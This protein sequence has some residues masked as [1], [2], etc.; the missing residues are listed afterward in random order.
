[1]LSG[2][3]S[4]GGFRAQNCRYSSPRLTL[5]LAEGGYQHDHKTVLNSLQRQGLRAMEAKKFKATTNSNHGLVAPQSVEY[6]FH[7]DSA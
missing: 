2:R 3:G 7:C 5:N 6:G 1:M 4:G